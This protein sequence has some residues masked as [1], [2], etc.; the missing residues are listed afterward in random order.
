MKRKLI[1]L[2]AINLLA[3]GIASIHAQDSGPLIDKLVQKGILNDQEAED[4]R[5]D[6]VKDYQT[7]SAG[8][9]NISSPVTELKLYGDGRFR[10]QYDDQ[11]TQTAGADHVTQRS[12]FR[13]RLRLNADFKLTNNFFGGVQIETGQA[14]DGANETVQPAYTDSA[15]FINR[16]FLGVNIGDWGTLVA[17]K[18]KNPFYT[19]DLVWDPDISPYGLTESVALDKVFSSSGSA[20]QETAGYGKDGKRIVSY[21]AG[22][23]GSDWG[24]FKLSLVAGQFV[25]DTNNNEAAV[26]GD[27]KNDA[28]QF[29]AQLVGSYTFENKT[30]ITFAPG[31]IIYNAADVGGDG[32]ATAIQANNTTP[33]TGAV[34]RID[35]NNDGIADFTTDPVTGAITVSTGS[36]S[37]ETRDLAIVTAPG[38]IKFPIGSLQGR[39]YWDFAYNTA[40]H[41]RYDDVYGFGLQIPTGSGL[42]TPVATTQQRSFTDQDA[43][44]WLAGFEIGAGKGKGAWT[45]FANYRETGLA[46]VDPNLN[47]SDFAGGKLN[48]RGFKFGTTYG[49]TDAVSLA[50]TGFVTYNLDDNLSDQFGLANRNTYNAVQVDLNFKF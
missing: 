41:K 11:Q 27:A 37:G 10:Y 2:I 24:N 48:T 40:G 13:Y 42:V 49:I 50:L 30:S 1:P 9:L 32:S 34:G 7:T 23:S 20:G 35:A 18:Q 31:F 3:G 22:T 43:L 25:Y 45:L 8:K 16:L 39:F 5:A 12:F 47:D 19:T 6:L 36:V 4:L 21:T 38:E 33:F 29:V 15:I 14:A 44:A 28:Y 46:S 26:N 17:G